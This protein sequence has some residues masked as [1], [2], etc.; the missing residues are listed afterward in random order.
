MPDY[1]KVP[2]WT[3]DQHKLADAITVTVDMLPK[4]SAKEIA[5][6]LKWWMDW[7]RYA[8]TKDR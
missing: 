4:L 2:E 5:S 3:P 7:T 6:V 1:P 8:N